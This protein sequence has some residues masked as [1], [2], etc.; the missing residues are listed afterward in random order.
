MRRI[1]GAFLRL[2]GRLPL[3]YHYFWGD[4]A[5]WVLRRLLRYRVSIV[6]TNLAR[7]FPEL[8]YAALEQ[9]KRRFYRHFGEIVAETL[10]LAGCRGERGIARFRRQALVE[11]PDPSPLNRLHD[12]GRPVM[13]LAAHTGNWELLGTLLSTT[14]GKPCSVRPAD[15]AVVYKR[16]TSR[17]WDAVLRENRCGL[18]AHAGFDGY[19]ES[20]QMLRF[21]LE[22]RDEPRVYLFPMDQAPYAGT[23]RTAVGT[24]LHQETAAMTGGAALA[25]KLGM[26]VVY[27]RFR[28]ETRGRYTVEYLPICDDAAQMETEEIVR[29]YYALLEADIKAQPFN[30]LWTHKRWKR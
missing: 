22:H 18:V 11:T 26:A 2:H 1:V 24:F 7:S 15:I 5:A 13:V 14:R 9:V 21:A 10:W 23:S 20:K 3:A 25:R 28:C 29:R 12:T 4:V 17:L 16:L 27:L 30:Y 8:D 6:D 19:V